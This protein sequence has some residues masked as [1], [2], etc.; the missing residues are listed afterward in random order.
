MKKRSLTVRGTEDSG[1][2]VSLS[3]SP[4]QLSLCLVPVDGAVAPSNT[5]SS[6]ATAV[7]NDYCASL[8]RLTELKS[9]A[10]MVA[11]TCD[12]GLTDRRT[13]SARPAWA[14]LKQTSKQ[15][16]QNLRNAYKDDSVSRCV[17]YRTTSL[18]LT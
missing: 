9:S 17:N 12:L 14:C 15:I 10:R 5:A 16:T 4:K 8:A 6:A 1:G 11:H 7:V 18:S 3:P 2:G 13:W